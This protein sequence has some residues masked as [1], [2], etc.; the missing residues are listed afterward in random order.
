[1]KT[2]YKVELDSCGNPDIGEDPYKQ[3]EGAWAQMAHVMTIEEAQQAV[4]EYIEK[5]NLRGSQFAGGSVWTEQNE[6]VGR[7]SYNGR[8]WNKDHEYGKMRIF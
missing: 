3:I 5:H 4:R 6:Y 1:M 2:K 8:F 7:I